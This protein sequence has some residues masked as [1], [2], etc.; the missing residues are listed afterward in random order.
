MIGSNSAL[1]GAPICLSTG[2]TETKENDIRIPGLGD[3][4]SI[5]RTW[6]STWP[7]SQSIKQI[8]IFG[9]HWRSTYEEYI[10]TGSDGYLKYSEVMG[11]G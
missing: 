2:N 9:S 6:N 11:I 8:G 7:P 4:L 10:F 1:G 5:T 3:G